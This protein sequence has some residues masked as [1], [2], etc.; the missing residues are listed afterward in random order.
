MDIGNFRV[1]SEDVKGELIPVANA[2][3][4]EIIKYTKL[5]A[6]SLLMLTCLLDSIEFVRL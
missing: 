1:T 2:I 6:S 5:T 3:Q 4:P